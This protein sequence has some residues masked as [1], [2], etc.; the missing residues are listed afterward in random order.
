MSTPYTFYFV[1]ETVLH[2]AAING[3]YQ[4]AKS[5]IEKGV[6]VHER[7]YCGWQPLHE[8][9]NHG[10]L[11]IVE[12]LLDKGADINDPGGPHCRGMTPLHD[13]AQNGHVE[14]VN[15]LIARGAS[16]SRS[17]K[18]GH[19][20]LDL[21]MHSIDDDN[22]DDDVNENDDDLDV[23]V[24]EVREEL[25]RILRNAMKPAKRQ[26]DKDSE[27]RRRDKIELSDDSDGG[28]SQDFAKVISIKPG[29]I[30]RKRKNAVLESDEENTPRN[31]MNFNGN[32][33]K[34]AKVSE[35]VDSDSL[36][37]D[38]S[39]DRYDRKIVESQGTAI[40]K[41][42]GVLVEDSDESS[43]DSVGDQGILQGKSQDSEDRLDSDPKNNQWPPFSELDIDSEHPSLSLEPSHTNT[44]ISKPV[45]GNTTS[46]TS[47]SLSR[48]NKNTSSITY[49][50]P[51]T[52]N[53]Q[54]DSRISESQP[55]LIPENEYILTTTDDWLINDIPKTTGKRKRC[56]NI[57]SMLCD[58]GS[59]CNTSSSSRVR[60]VSNVSS[61]GTQ[62]TRVVET[63]RG[64][65]TNNGAKNRLRQS[66]LTVVNG[67]SSPSEPEPVT[68]SSLAS[69]GTSIS[70][71]P[72]RLRV[73]V[74]DK[75]FLI[76]CPIV[77]GERKTVRWLAEQV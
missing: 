49:V 10:N 45:L 41:T 13:A 24:A 67:R 64:H 40:S 26:S 28:L 65:R 33:S 34:V 23:E 30:S 58:S 35:N 19:T 68:T 31:S 7:D 62:S 44:S 32:K 73:K 52:G 11:S 4:L 37:D 61:T 66:R 46:R 29:E 47:E 38:D 25:A 16:V 15:L 75:I 60:T 18:D 5:S 21:V 69:G 3:N 6:S 56:G 9:C 51:V 42:R 1:G 53:T 63:S 43:R 50:D 59:S 54:N 77:P 20:P 72:M 12:L 71:A 14:V 8:A 70:E 76:P 48:K 36:L 57:L 39:Q 22:D 2:V 27:L 74:E 17:N 55:A